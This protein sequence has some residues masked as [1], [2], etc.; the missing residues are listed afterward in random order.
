MSQNTSPVPPGQTKKH[1]TN[2]H[3]A[4]VCAV[5]IELRDYADQL[6]YLTEYVLGKSHYRIDMLVIR[7]LS[8]Q[9]I[10][11]NIARIFKDYNLFEIKGLGSSLK[12]R[13]YYKAIGYAGILVDQMD[14]SD[15]CSA[16]DISITFFSFHYPMRLM[17]H[18]VKER[19]LE[20]VKSSPGIY[21]I[22]KETFSAQIIVT[23]ELPPEENLYLRCL[24]DRLQDTDL[25]NRLARDYEEHQDQDIYMRYMNQLTKANSKKKGAS[26]MVCEGILN[27]CGTSSKEIIERTKR[28]EEAYYLPKIDELTSS[29]AALVLS[30]ELLTSQNDY[31]KDL[32][33]QHNITFD[34][35]AVPKPANGR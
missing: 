13:S 31:L 22:N 7:K 3:E 28:E 24:T 9:P 12:I 18:L 8:Q 32:L 23:K 10:P 34:L 6:D 29:N 15:Q 25:I 19:N 30:N 17:E 33:R 26:P 2:W 20:V 11:K 16:L 14:H 27:I 4:A 21:N 1:Y 35:N 5:Q